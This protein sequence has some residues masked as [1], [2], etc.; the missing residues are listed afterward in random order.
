M[1][2]NQK[3]SNFTIT[4]KEGLAKPQ[5]KSGCNKKKR[6]SRRL[7]A[8]TILLTL[9]LTGCG[10]NKSDTLTITNVSYDPTREFY[11]AYNPVFEKY[12]EDKFG[13]KVEVMKAR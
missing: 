7:A 2:Q 6:R 9:V 11:E 8:V 5:E 1:K 12:Y 13:K 10:R 3:F 4:Y